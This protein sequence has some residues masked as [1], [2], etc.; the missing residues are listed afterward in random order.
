VMTYYINWYCTLHYLTSH[1]GVHTFI[2]YL[3]FPA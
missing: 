1:Y 2:R 3:T